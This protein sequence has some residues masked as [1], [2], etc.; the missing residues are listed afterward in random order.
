VNAADRAA[1]FDGVALHDSLRGAVDERTLE[2]VDRRR[3]TAVVKT[4]GWLVRRLLLAADLLG[5]LAALAIAEWLVNRHSRNGALDPRAEVIAFVVS[6]PVWVVVAKLYGLYD[7]DEER[8]D[9]STADDLAGVFH[10]VTVC[11][12]LFW[13]VSHLTGVAHPPPSKLLIFWAGAIALIS[14]GR[15]G[16]R[17]LA[18]RSV[19]YLQNTIIVGAGDVG[20]LIAK[21]LLQHP[22]YGINLVGFVDAEPKERRDDLE[23]LALL[24]DT[25]RLP[26]IIRLFGIERVIVA[27][28]NESHQETLRMVRLLRDMDMQVDVVPRLFETVGPNVGWHML[29]GLP[30]VSVPRLRLSRSSALVKRTADVVLASCALVVLLPVLLAVAVAVRLDSAGPV[31]YK[32]ERVGRGGR[33][34]RV[35][36]FRTMFLRACRGQRYGGANAETMFAD[37]LADPARAN[38]FRQTYKLAD[39]PRVTRVGRILRKTSLDELP[40]LLNVLTGELSLVGPRAITA[41]ELSRYGDRVD[42]LLGFRPG[43]TGYW[44]VN[45]RSRLS[46][47]DRVRLDLSYITSWS[48]R[49]DAQI[50]ART[51]R[52]LIA[53][54]GAV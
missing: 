48:L 27:F 32:H 15:A 53:G 38:E 1:I 46:Y 45:G 12:F 17:A 19:A 37:L 52:V 18:R 50:L 9:H 8:T 25:G 3:R 2:I 42:S 47:E 13:A 36:K 28:S 39:D 14:A 35:T 51:L 43:V 21:K 20:Q 5:L 40:Q 7:H 44:Q 29:E 23:H 4:R 6:L 10:M 34:I 26:A 30:L 41:D 33:A 22:E 49:L 11:T 16:A 24:G 31:L 54:R